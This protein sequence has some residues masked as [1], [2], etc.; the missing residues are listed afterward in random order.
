MNMKNV[1]VIVIAVVLILVICGGFFLFSQNQNS[2]NPDELTEVEKVLVK[3]LKKDYPKTPREV[4]KLYN[5]IVQCYHTDNL[6]KEDLGKLVDQMMLLWDKDMLAKNSR[7]EY[8][9]TVVSDIE[10]YKKTK[11]TI[12]SISIC[13]SNEV[14][15]VTDDRN[16]DK[17]AFVN[18][19]YFVNTDGTFT[20]SH[21]RVGVRQDENGNWKIIGVTLTKGESSEDDE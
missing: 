4:V 2:G 11:K 12:T 10:L 7:D 8:Y 17:L 5:R 21:M 20:N 1:R 9:A 19:T 14:D 13:N 18:T 15:Y 16:G 6:K 3:D